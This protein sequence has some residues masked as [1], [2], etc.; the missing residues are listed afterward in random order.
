M[1]RKEG[2]TVKN[3]WVSHVLLINVWSLFLT[4]GASAQ[5]KCGVITSTPPCYSE[6]V[7]IP[8]VLG[9]TG[10]I[11]STTAL[12]GATGGPGGPV[13]GIMFLTAST[14]AT[15]P[16]GTA[17]MWVTQTATTSVSGTL[18]TIV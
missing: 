10:A 3:L 18:T 7:A 12:Y 4:S 14:N 1:S 11:C 9:G 2:I 15:C 13:L 17:A 6:S 16:A 5:E 8:G